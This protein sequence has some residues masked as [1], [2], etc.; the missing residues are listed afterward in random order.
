LLIFRIQQRIF[1]RKKFPFVFFH[2]AFTS[3]LSRMGPCQA[4]KKPRK[5]MEAYKM[6]QLLQS[7]NHHGKFKYFERQKM[8]VSCDWFWALKTIRPPI[9]KHI[10]QK[11]VSEINVNTKGD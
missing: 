10:R 7:K 5:G 3:G 2:V 9:T 1:L 11:K 6:R 4:A 8:F